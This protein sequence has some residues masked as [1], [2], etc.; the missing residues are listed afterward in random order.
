[1]KTKVKV[2]TKSFIKYL[3][4][5]FKVLT[6]DSIYDRKLTPVEHSDD[7]CVEVWYE[8]KDSIEKVNQ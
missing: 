4:R 6:A 8:A 1:M 2:K 5:T 7:W 3:Y